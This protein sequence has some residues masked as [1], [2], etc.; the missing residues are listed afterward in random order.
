MFYR[1]SEHDFKINVDF[2]VCII[3]PIIQT[4]VHDEYYIS[5]ITKQWVAKSST[6]WSAGSREPGMIVWLTKIGIT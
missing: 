2:C 4:T 1:L 5:L 6:D 3:V